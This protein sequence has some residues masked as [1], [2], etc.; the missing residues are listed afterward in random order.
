MVMDWNQVPNWFMCFVVICL[1]A[2]TG[3][4]IKEKNDDWKQFFVELFNSRNEHEKRL[5]HLEG[6]HE[7]MKE[8]C[9]RRQHKDGR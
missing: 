3:W 4:S 6:E 2:Y 5:S 7:G 1:C 9:D 8:L